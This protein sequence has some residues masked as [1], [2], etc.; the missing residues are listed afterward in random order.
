MKSN[1]N[2]VVIG[3]GTGL[4]V[5][6]QG[7]KYKF[8]NIT[9]IVTVADD[10]GGSGV[11]REDLGMLPPGD[12][13]ACILALSNTEPTMEK[14]LK[15]RFDEGRLKG[16]SFG[17][18][19]IAAMNGISGDFQS[20][21]KKISD[22][23]SVTGKVLPVSNEDVHLV[24]ELENGKKIKGESN[25]PKKVIEMNSRIKN[26]S[27]NKSNV[28]CIDEVSKSIKKADIIIIGPGSLFTSIMPSL[29][30]K[31]VKDSLKI[32]RAKKI[33]VTNLMTQHGETDKF[34]VKDHYQAIIRHLG[35][36]FFD[37]VLVN[38]GYISDDVKRKYH[39]DNS[40]FVLPNENDI[41]FFKNRN[42]N[43]ITD[44]FVEIVKGYVR[45]DSLKIAKKLIDLVDTKLYK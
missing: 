19:F 24:A 21:V 36:D 40:E 6:L 18:L 17:N 43:L 7:F 37:T 5:L 29:I 44:N 28:S 32:S 38:N 25:I 41:D 8:K 23:L 13:R 12:I 3:G 22:I 1:L 20:A 27:Y 2:V 35:F 11:L 42:I 30:I 16:Q 10:G 26:I 15:Y 31:E 45:H 4:S 39:E 33:L 9:A 14:L 34:S